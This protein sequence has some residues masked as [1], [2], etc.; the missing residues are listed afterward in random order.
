MC[1]GRL[2]SGQRR[3]ASNSYHSVYY[4]QI[5]HVWGYGKTVWPSS[6]GIFLH[7]PSK[8]DKRFCRR[9][10]RRFGR[11]QRGHADFKRSGC[12]LFRDFQH[13]RM[14]RTY[15]SLVKHLRRHFQP[16]CRNAQKN[17]NF[18]NVC[19]SDGKRGRTWQSVS[20]E[21]KSG[22]RRDNRKPRAYG[23]WHRNLR[24]SRT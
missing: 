6:D 22:F 19:F 13:L 16:D 14:W 7:P 11:R 20:G 4:V 15:R 18:G 24:K 5:R 17:G 9:K 2:P 12:K 3:T 1:S 23:S 10:N 21:H 8:P